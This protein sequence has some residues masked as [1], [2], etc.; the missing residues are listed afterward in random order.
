M[1]E[2]DHE[3]KKVDSIQYIPI[4]SSLIC[5]LQ[6]EDVLGTIFSVQGLPDTETIDTFNK[7]YGFKKNLLFSTSNHHLQINLYQDDFDVTNPFGNKVKKFCLG[8]IPSKYRAKVKDLQLAILY[9][10]YFIEKYGYKKILELLMNDLIILETKGISVK[11]EDIVHHF[12]GSISMVVA[13]NLA[14]HAL[15]GYFCNF[16]QFSLN[17]LQIL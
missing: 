2:Y 5:L 12:Q 10:S 15:G 16:I 8:N 4:L 3:T 1:I 13:D 7:G 14:A 9:P 6:H 17:V 11:Y